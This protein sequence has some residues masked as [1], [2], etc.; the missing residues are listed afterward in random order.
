MRLRPTGGHAAAKLRQQTR[1]FSL[2]SIKL[3]HLH[4]IYVSSSRTYASCGSV[5]TN[6]GQNGGIVFRNLNAM[7]QHLAFARRHDGNGQLPGINGCHEIAENIPQ[8]S[9]SSVMLRWAC[10][11]TEQCARDRGSRATL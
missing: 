7:R 2:I 11:Q 8:R 5:A 3:K 9:R 10:T 1:V 6:Q 4:V